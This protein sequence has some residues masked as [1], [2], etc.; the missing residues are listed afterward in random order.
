MHESGRPAADRK[1]PRRTKADPT[2]RAAEA[3]LAQLIRE[4]LAP[5]ILPEKK[6]FGGTCFLL[7]GN[8]LCGTYKGD[9]IF[10]VGVD[11]HP[12]ALRE[13][14]ASAFV[15]QGKELTGW[16]AVSGAVLQSPEEARIWIG[17]AMLF[18]GSL[19][20]K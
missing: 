16:I 20:S 15:M 7:N 3:S 1:K 12:D 5:R 10:R 17:R 19:A 14:G 18:V 8:M 11:A 4:A 6:M 9:V 13:K 2:T